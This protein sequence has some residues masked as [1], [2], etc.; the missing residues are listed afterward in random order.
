M[1]I[2]ERVPDF[3]GKDWDSI[4][5]HSQMYGRGTR[6]N[7]HS[8]H[9]SL[10]SF[11][12]YWHK[13]WKPSW[14]GELLVP[15]DKPIYDELVEKPPKQSIDYD[16]TDNFFQDTL[17]SYSILPIPNRCV[18]LG[19]GVFHSVG[20]VDPDAGNHMRCSI[21]AFLVKKEDS[22]DKPTQTD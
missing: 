12:W 2:I 10:G 22:Q 11:T 9:H 18:L 7:W 3:V 13:E 20:R 21:V 1:D 6:I 14:G 5:I 4:R 19:P 17:F 8:D 15:F 16:W